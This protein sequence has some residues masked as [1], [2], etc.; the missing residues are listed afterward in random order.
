MTK[1]TAPTDLDLAECASLFRPDVEEAGYGS[2]YDPP[3][4][5][6]T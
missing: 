3:Y 5:L 6:S 1:R 2:A 4:A